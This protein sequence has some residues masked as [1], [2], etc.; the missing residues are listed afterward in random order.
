MFSFYSSYSGTFVEPHRRTLLCDQPAAKLPTRAP[1]VDTTL[2]DEEGG[3]LVFMPDGKNIKGGTLEGLVE[4]LLENTASKF[5]KV[6]YEKKNYI[7]F[8]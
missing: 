6:C 8:I 2:D 4:H 3:E 5:A 1:A 7:L